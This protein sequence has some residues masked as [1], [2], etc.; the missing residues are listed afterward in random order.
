M[1]LVTPEEAW[2]I[3]ERL[4]AENNGH[5]GDTN[6][7]I[8][9][10]RDTG[11][12]AGEVAER[13]GLDAEEIRVAGYFHDIGKLFTADTEYFTFHEIEGARYLEREAVRLGITDSQERADRIAQSI[14]PHF[15]VLEQFGMDEYERWKPGLRDTDSE[16]LII[17]TWQEAVIAYADATN[18]R[19]ERLTL[20]ERIADM[21]KI[22]ERNGNPR[23]AAVEKAEP[24]LYRLRDAIEVAL[25]KGKTNDT[26]TTL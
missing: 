1:T 22:D 7:F 8:Q 5:F 3:F 13:L 25:D 12:I 6:G 15:A 4:V 9:H 2:E 21:K 18:V 14:R 16:L 23:L 17:G 20:R 24:R 10:S 26:Y 11:D 19:G